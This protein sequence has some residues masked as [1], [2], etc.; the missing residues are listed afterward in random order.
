MSNDQNLPVLIAEHRGAACWLRLNRPQ[1]LN[2]VTHEVLEA[3]QA[4]LDRI[5][6]D[7]RIRAVVL[8]GTGKAF[9]AG[10]DLKH[11]KGRTDTDDPEQAAAAN[12]LF[13]AAFGAVLD[14]LEAFPKPVIAAVNGVAVAAGIEFLLCC[15]FVLAGAGA[16]I[17][18]AHA[19]YGLIPGGGS[20]ARLPRRVG[21][22]LAK[23][24]IYTGDILPAQEFVGTGLVL[25]V[26]PDAQ[27]EEE[28]QQ[29]AEKLA[30][31]SPLALRRTK[32]L[33]DDGLQMPLE[34]ALRHEREVNRQHAASHDRRE[35]LAAFAQRRTPN[36]IGR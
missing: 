26:V 25:R 33:I 30:S 27:L 10:A 3:M 19:N 29:L 18:D 16:R 21:V 24:L 1:A 7:E 13:T 2:A 6:S 12:A 22:S 9:C 5:E 17:G 20:T 14:R 35:G 31:R 32:R 34:L 8:T 11:A 15:D 4:E 28:V 36:F 23:Y